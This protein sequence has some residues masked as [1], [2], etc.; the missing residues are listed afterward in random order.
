M[1]YAGLWNT[2]DEAMTF[3]AA[4][5]TYNQKG[6]TIPSQ[7]RYIRY[8][9]HYLKLGMP[10]ARTLLVKEV[11][12]SGM[13]VS[14]GDLRFSII[15]KTVPVLKQDVEKAKKKDKSDEGLSFLCNDVPVVG[16]VKMQIQ[17]LTKGTLS[18]KVSSCPSCCSPFSNQCL[19][20]VYSLSHSL[21][22]LKHCSSSAHPQ[23]LCCRSTVHVDDCPP[24]R[25]FLLCRAKLQLSH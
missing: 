9:E 25:S 3:Y 5:R 13:P 4:M 16:D 1:L 10:P 22:S 11:R 8:F 18:E 23:A 17:D 24:W 2:T 21:V 6:V 20:P 15:I 14:K 19:P 12:L 7:I